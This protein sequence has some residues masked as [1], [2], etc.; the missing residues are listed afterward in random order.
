MAG[1]DANILVHATIV[2]DR[3]KFEIASGILK[4]V[5]EGSRR[6]VV[7]TQILG[8]FAR[9]ATEKVPRPLP[10]R[11]AYAFLSLLAHSPSCT[12]LPYTTDHVLG[13]LRSGKPFW[14]SVI[15]Q[16]LKEHGVHEILTENVK[17]FEGSG[18]A[19]TDPFR[20][21]GRKR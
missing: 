7:T 8:E 20:E 14:D 16:T 12:V 19:A 13:A 9:V 1:I 5:L 17:D 11:K 2:Q 18:I 10:K 15:A 3:R 21:T 4:D 6:A